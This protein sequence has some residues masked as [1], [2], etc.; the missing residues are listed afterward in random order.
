MEAAEEDVCVDTDI[1]VDYLRKREPGFSIFNKRRFNAAIS[2]VTVFELLFGANLSSRKEERILELRSLFE[3]H[4]IL[5]FD[6]ASAEH[7]S[8]VGAELRVKGESIEIRDLFNASI[9]LR[10]NLAILTRNKN[11]YAR[12]PGLKVISS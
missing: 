9:C 4:P 1:L 2:T 3:Q 11:H 10:Q 6:E 8:E 5:P 12:V 7:A